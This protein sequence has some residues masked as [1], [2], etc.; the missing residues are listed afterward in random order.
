M[1]ARLSIQLPCDLLY[2]DAVGAL[3]HQLCLNLEQQGAEPGL[4]IQVVSAFNEAFNNLVQHARAAPGLVD[5]LVE[6]SATKLAIELK[7]DGV[8]YDYDNV[9][10]PDLDQLPESGLGI[11]IMRSFMSE[12]Q[13]TP[14]G[15]NAKNV[16]R[17]SR[18]LKRTGKVTHT[19]KRGSPDDA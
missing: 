10:D 12:I 1:A 6:I 5:V 8:P 18:T 9:K 13:Y 4:G 17:M 7:D 15:G 14:G 2:R 16:L 11:F 3:I 19:S